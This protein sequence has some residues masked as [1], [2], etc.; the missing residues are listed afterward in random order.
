[1][2]KSF[3]KVTAVLLATLFCASLIPQSVAADETTADHFAFGMEYDWSNMNADFESMTGL[4]MDDILGDVMQSADD[5]G[6]E[7]LILEELTGTSSMIVDQYEDGTTMLVQVS[8]SEIVM[9]NFNTVDKVAAY[10]AAHRS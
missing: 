6:I 10:I 8:M 3:S 5:A 1:M 2:R 9:E 7:L 4:P